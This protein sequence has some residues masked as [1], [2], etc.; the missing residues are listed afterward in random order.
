MS[1]IYSSG[2]LIVQNP[3][4]SSSIFLV[5][6]II[7]ACIEYLFTLS[8]EI[9]SN[10]FKTMFVT[11]AEE[12]LVLGVIS[13]L[14]SLMSSI[15][16]EFSVSPSWVLMF[17]WSHLCLLF[18]GV[19]Y[20][21]YL[22]ILLAASS[23]QNR[24]LRKFEGFRMSTGKDL[25][26]IEQNFKLAYSNFR[27]SCTAFGLSEEVIFADYVV[28]TEKQQLRALGDI[29]WKSWAALTT[30]IVINAVRTRAPAL[31]N[32]ADSSKAAIDVG[33]YILIL[34]FGPMALVVL[35]YVSLGRRFR[36]YIER[37]GDLVSA[38]EGSSRNAPLLTRSDLDDPRAFLLW[39]SPENTID[40]LQV[41]FLFLVWYSAVFC[42]NLLYVAFSVSGI[43]QTLLLIVGAIVPVAV[44]LVLFPRMLLTVAY[45]SSL[46]TSL[47]EGRVRYLCALNK[48]LTTAETAPAAEQPKIGP[49]ADSAGPVEVRRVKTKVFVDDE[50]L[51]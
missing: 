1:S 15:I 42:L 23:I 19:F 16:T 44:F 2:E 21:V 40:I 29:S 30:M 17:Q 48:G 4:E 6:V 8:S 34:G 31:I 18:M 14:L 38:E 47:D 12:F 43:Y 7:C 37:K 27:H 3:I 35:V 28:R 32:V 5:V 22:G 50:A 41:L 20:A 39:Q 24:T 46:G 25:R 45:L 13:L 9:K 49:S 26:V 10:F 51:L 33:S 11:I 36:Q